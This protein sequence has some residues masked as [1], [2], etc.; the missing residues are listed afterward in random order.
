VSNELIRPIDADTAHAIEETA[1]A[2]GKAIDAAVKSGAY[3][4]NVLGDLP[5]DLVG[6]AGDWVKHKRAR[7]W[8]EL[9]AET[10]KI[11]R[12]R[13]VK[14]REEVS[15]S[16][17]IPLIEAAVNEDRECLKGLWARLLA[18]A[19]DPAR[20]DQVRLS[21]IELLKRLDPLDA[22]VL[23]FLVPPAG[24]HFGGAGTANADL[25]E[26][27][28]MALTVDRVEA[29]YSLE[30]LH[31]LGCLGDHPDRI[32]RPRITAKAQLLVRAVSDR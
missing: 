13:G 22:R 17:A 21:L 9:N 18:N 11:L 12:E 27:I 5:H 25:A 16:I 28:A 8:V 1:K 32:P 6:I 4:G 14:N 19:M 2:S 24:G 26:V 3:V 30:H 29:F 23:E 20:S 7:R 10:E 15:P 31:E